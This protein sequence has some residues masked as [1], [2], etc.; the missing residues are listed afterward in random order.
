MA[1]S[2]RGQTKLRQLGQRHK[3]SQSPRMAAA[4]VIMH[5]FADLVFQRLPRR[6][7]KESLPKGLSLAAEGIWLQSLQPAAHSLFQQFSSELVLIL[8]LGPLS[9]ACRNH[10][11]I[12]V[13]ESSF[14]FK[15]RK[16]AEGDRRGPRQS[17]PQ[18]EELVCKMSKTEA[19]SIIG[20]FFFEL[21]SSQIACSSFSEPSSWSSWGN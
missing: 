13:A 8:R 10:A 14:C 15:A 17:L 9:E 16:T 21:A 4:T 1:A 12:L 7:V 6:R 20:Q 2:G 3:P 19:A 18:R 5:S 11:R